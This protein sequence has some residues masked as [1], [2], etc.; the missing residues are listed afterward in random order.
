M[1]THIRAIETRYGG[2]RFRS[3]LEARWAVFFD[4]LDLKWEY[5]PEGFVTSAGPYLPDFRVWTPQGEPVW[6]EVKPE[7]V[8]VSE[9]FSAFHQ[10]TYDSFM[11]IPAEHRAG[12]CPDRVSLLSGDPPAMLTSG[13]VTLCPRCGHIKRGAP[14]RAYTIRL[15]G[16]G[17]R[18]GER[19]LMV[20]CS[21][22]FLETQNAQRDHE[23]TNPYLPD[24][25][26]PFGVGVQKRSYRT[27]NGWVQGHRD[28]A[29][30][31]M[32]AAYA[33]RA[34]RFEHGERG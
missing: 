21:H 31:V 8:R 33:A 28:M 5:E 19:V 32:E 18:A 11:S 16:Y 14:A 26:E 30:H 1:S 22:C 34:A 6:Y 17:L 3:R 12:L 9:K 27:S 25:L 20:Y 4:A 13:K 24:I 7:H 23:T 15:D 10:M 29:F 2:Y